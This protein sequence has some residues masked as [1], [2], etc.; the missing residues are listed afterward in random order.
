MRV[1]GLSTTEDQVRRGGSRL[2]LEVGRSEWRWKRWWT[3]GFL[4]WNLLVH[5]QYTRSESMTDE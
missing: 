4:V 2:G 3:N 1:Y 5:S